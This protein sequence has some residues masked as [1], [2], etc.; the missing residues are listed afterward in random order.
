[1]GF[2]DSPESRRR[3]ALAKLDVGRVYAQISKY[4][5]Y[6]ARSQDRGAELAQ[7]VFA[8]AV[9]PERSHWD[10]ERDP[11]LARFLVGRVN[12]ALAAERKKRRVRADPRAVASIEARYYGAE[13]GP[14]E[15]M[16]ERQ[17]ATH[18]AAMLRAAFEG[19][20]D[21]LERKVLEQYEDGVLTAAEQ[22]RALGVDIGDVY[23]ARRRIA[24]HVRM[25]QD[26]DRELD[27]PAERDA[28]DQE[29][30]T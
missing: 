30:G 19:Y 11:D 18:T 2:F 1:M 5:R 9:D 14:D 7:R 16:E 29:V 3:A 12:G 27:E 13:L 8:E 20:G 15:Q 10:P 4:A 23:R 25:L 6:R 21:E 17:R 28:R 22:A 26:A 24:R